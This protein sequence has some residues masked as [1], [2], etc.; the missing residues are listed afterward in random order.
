MIIFSLIVPTV[1]R[2]SELEALFETLKIQIFDR[3]EVIIVDQNDDNRL[4]DLISKYNRIFNLTHLKSSLKGASFARNFGIDHAQGKIITFPD[5]DCEYPPDVLEKVYE[6]FRKNSKLD[7]ITINSTD[8]N[9]EGGI[10]NLSSKSGRI[11]K[12]NILSKLVEFTIFIKK[13]S[14]GNIRFN[15][16]FGPGAAS[17]LWCDEGPDLLLR[18]INN[19]NEFKYFA[20]LVIFHPNPVK[21]YDAKSFIRSYNYGR[22]RGW[23]L[24]LHNYPFWFVVKVWCYYVAGILIGLA[25]LNFK[26]S[27]FYYF[28]LKGRILGYLTDLK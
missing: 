2:T 16:D 15:E 6:I 21:N 22:A 27:K 8:K 17:N 4:N 10:G 25:D 20:N 9:F 13:K 26:K 5:D 23:F 14:L 1:N 7:G 12:L 18:L 19:G 11:D 28:G 3:F 24:K